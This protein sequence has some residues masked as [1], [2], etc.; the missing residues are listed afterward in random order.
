LY[1]TYCLLLDEIPI[2]EVPF[3]EDPTIGSGIGTGDDVS[4]AGNMLTPMSV[5]DGFSVVPNEQVG[6]LYAYRIND[7]A[8]VLGTR[9]A[10]TFGASIGIGSVASGTYRCLA[11]NDNANSQHII[12]ISINSKFINFPSLV[13]LLASSCSFSFYCC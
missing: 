11:E 9:R 3:R 7:S 10:S 13:L 4:N 5:N 12:I 8:V 6:Q 2:P 1:N